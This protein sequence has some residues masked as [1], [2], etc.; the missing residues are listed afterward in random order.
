MSRIDQLS[1][2][3]KAVVPSS[4]CPATALTQTV[5]TAALDQEAA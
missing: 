4:S 1:S 3:Q 2:K 5:S